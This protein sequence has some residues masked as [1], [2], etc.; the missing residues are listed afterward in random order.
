MNKANALRL[1]II[2]V[3]YNSFKTI[4]DSINSVLSQSYKNFE[5]III[6]GGSNDGTLDVICEYRNNIDILISERDNGI[7]DALNKGIKVATGDVIGI[8]HA[9]DVYFNENTL[10]DINKTF[11]NKITLDGVY[12][13]LLYTKQ[14][15]LSKIQRYWR[16]KEFNKNLLIFGWMPPHP[17]LFLKKEVFVKFGIYNTKFKISADY[18]FI[19]RIFTKKL[20]IKHLQS[21]VCKMRLGGKS[22]VKFTNILIKSYEDYK[23][24]KINKIGGIF[25]LIFKNLSKIIQFFPLLHKLKTRI[26]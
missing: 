12:G 22:N 16:S 15:D 5:Y 10:S 6:D 9:D 4:R 24:L 23:A 20:E 19:L 21:V 11:S 25:S 7:Y 1:S 2:T 17:T 8:L 18:D 3:V 14:N 13:N 26:L